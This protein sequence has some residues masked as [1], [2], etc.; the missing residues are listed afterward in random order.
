MYYVVR[1]QIKGF[2][3]IGADDPGVRGR[4][5]HKRAAGTTVYACEHPAARILIYRV[6]RVGARG[7]R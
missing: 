4:T 6:G 2:I 3:D 7:A 1:S 5:G